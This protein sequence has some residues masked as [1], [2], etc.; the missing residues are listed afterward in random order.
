MAAHMRSSLQALLLAA[1]AAPILA[2]PPPLTDRQATL[3][4]VNCLQ[5]HALPGLGAPLAGDRAGWE[6]VRKR[7]E[8]VV[9][10]NVLNGIRGMPPMGYCGA[11][12]EAD[13]RAM[14]RFLADLPTPAEL[15][16]TGLPAKPTEQ[17][18]PK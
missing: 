18:V 8:D 6:S 9:L 15:R 7:G 4:N 17:G 3:L 14:I 13:F 5:C 1:A 16:E 12:T 2:N 10:R 11:C